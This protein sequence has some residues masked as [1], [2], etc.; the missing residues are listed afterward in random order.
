VNTEPGIAFLRAVGFL[1]LGMPEDALSELGELPLD[2]QSSPV[3]LH[4]KVD[5]LFRLKEWP[6][7]LEICLP[8]LEAHPEDPG[9]WI[10]GAYAMRRAD[11]VAAAEPFLRKALELHPKHG[12]IV[13]NLAC[14]ACVQ[15]RHDEARELLER[16]DAIDKE[17][18]LAMAVGDADLAAIRPWVVE[19]RA[20]GIMKPVGQ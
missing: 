16:A 5:A 10:Q 18:F 8:M 17:T 3:A 9:W 13:Y 7:A 6:A 12:L 19:R 15:G 14:Y 1:E 2:Q 4:L 11:S 20:V